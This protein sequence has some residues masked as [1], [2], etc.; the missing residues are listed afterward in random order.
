MNN[1]QNNQTQTV[2]EQ[3]EIA[4]DQLVKQIKEIVAEGNVRRLIFRAP[5]DKVLLEITMTAGAVLGGVMVLSAW[6]L[7]AIA[8]IAA[9]AGRI[10][11]EVVRDVA[12]PE[13]VE[14]RAKAPTPEKSPSS[15]GKQ[16]IKIQ[17]ED[18]EPP[19]AY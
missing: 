13:M 19:T 4:S 10:R 8:A 5:D 11:V 6:W 17:I 1:D 7:A 15:T 16:K 3:I 9:L 2:T 18:D 12:A 14:G